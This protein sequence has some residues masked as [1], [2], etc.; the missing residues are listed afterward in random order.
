M[1]WIFYCLRRKVSQQYAKCF[2]SI[3]KELGYFLD[4]KPIL[5]EDLEQELQQALQ[6]KETPTIILR[7]E[8]S[9]AIE[10]AVTVMDIANQNNFKVILAYDQIKMSLIDTKYKRKSL[11]VTV[12]LLSMLL[13]VMFY[14]GLSYLDPP[15][16]NGIAI[17]FGTTEFGMGNDQPLEKIKSAPKT[18]SAP[19][20]AVKT[21]E[22][23]LTAENEESVVIPSKKESV[24]KN[25]SKRGG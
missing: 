13:L 20:K 25:T 4:N 18:E 19:Q 15:I 3:N 9:V 11:T 12:F 21:Q 6:G 10:K 24:V 7:V 22:E 17:N 2:C 5:P 1:H 14:I 23:V 16:E 8:E